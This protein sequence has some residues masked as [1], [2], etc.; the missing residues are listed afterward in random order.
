MTQYLE[1]V[2]TLSICVNY[3]QNLVIKVN[4]QGFLHENKY[5]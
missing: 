2:F 5:E 3:Q 4:V 1:A